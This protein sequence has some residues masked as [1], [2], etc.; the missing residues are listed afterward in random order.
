MI[1]GGQFFR[2]SCLVIENSGDQPIARFGIGYIFKPVL[3][4][5]YDDGVSLLLSVLHESIETA[6]GRNIG[7]PRAAAREMLYPLAT[8]GQPHRA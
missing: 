8:A 6:E 7:K 2:R 4:D 5:S 1:Q 3:D